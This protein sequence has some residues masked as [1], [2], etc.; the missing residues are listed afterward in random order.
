MVRLAGDSEPEHVV[1]AA[2]I[3]NGASNSRTLLRVGRQRIRP[4]G[5]VL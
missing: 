2:S 3:P 4:T 5:P 1:R